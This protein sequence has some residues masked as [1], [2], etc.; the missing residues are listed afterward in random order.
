MK[1]N[2]SLTKVIQ[3]IHEHKD[4]LFNQKKTR[5]TYG[6]TGCVN[7]FHRRGSTMPIWNSSGNI[8]S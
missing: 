5:Q 3:K 1:G 8:P 7:S 4:K 6:P 2:E